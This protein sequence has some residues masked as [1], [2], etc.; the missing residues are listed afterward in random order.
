M[1]ALLLGGGGV[2]PAGFVQQLLEGTTVGECLFDLRCQFRRNVDAGATSIDA[3]VQHVAGV[4]VAAGT[5]RAVLAGAGA[6]SMT[7]G[8]ERCGPQRRG[9]RPEP[10]LNVSG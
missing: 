5:S 8:S 3:D 1:S 7:Q 9:L 4:L 2:A 10:A 6:C